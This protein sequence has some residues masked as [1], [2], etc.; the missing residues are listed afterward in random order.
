[1]QVLTQFDRWARANELVRAAVLTSSRVEPERG[2]DF[3]S[4]YDIE[5]Y[6]ADLEPFRRGDGWLDAF[7]PVMVR[8]PF[9]AVK[10]VPV[11]WVSRTFDGSGAS[12][13]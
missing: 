3:L 11:R 5:L 1:M 12:L 7:G 10:A 8:W 4:D 2:T 6:V 13:V 9:H